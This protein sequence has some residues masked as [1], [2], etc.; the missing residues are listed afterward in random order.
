MFIVYVSLLAQKYISYSLADPVAIYP[1]PFIISYRVLRASRTQ[2]IS[3][4]TYSTITIYS[5]EYELKLFLD[6]NIMS[7]QARV[8]S[9]SFI[10]VSELR[11]GLT[12]V[13]VLGSGVISL[14][15]GGS[16]V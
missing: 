9:Y 12:P 7:C 13:R 3:I 11:D 1:C 10:T 16:Y 8:N 4:E 5:Y 15:A 2:K 6:F 14:S